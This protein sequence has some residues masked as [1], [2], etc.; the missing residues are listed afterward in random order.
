MESRCA[1]IKV[2]VLGEFSG[3]EDQVTGSCT[4]YLG[5]RYN[6]GMTNSQVQNNDEDLEDVA[7]KHLGLRGSQL[8]RND[9]QNPITSGCFSWAPMVTA[10]FMALAM[11]Q[12]VPTL[13]G[14][15]KVLHSQACHSFLGFVSMGHTYNETPNYTRARFS[16]SYSRLAPRPMPV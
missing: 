13:P 15:C 16:W 2:S 1:V 3:V 5:S 4:Y 7:I 10:V 12:A 11:S 8:E 14:Q 9:G 6:M